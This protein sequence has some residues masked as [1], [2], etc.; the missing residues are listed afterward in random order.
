MKSNS[1]LSRILE[2]DIFVKSKDCVGY[3]YPTDRSMKNAPFRAT[4]LKAWVRRRNAAF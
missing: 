1:V 3:K 4:S 2:S